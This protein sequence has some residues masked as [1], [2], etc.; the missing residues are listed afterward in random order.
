MPGWIDVC[1]A[2]DLPPG[3]L[4]ACSLAGR[5]VAVCRLE[6]GSLRAVHDLCTHADALLSEGWIEGRCVVCPLHEARFDLDTGEARSLPATESVETFPVRE[7]QGRIL[8]KA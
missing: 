7:D 6:D 3:S 4:R 1:S 5:D 2:E 8:V